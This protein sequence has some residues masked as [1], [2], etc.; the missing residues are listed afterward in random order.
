MIPHPPPLCSAYTALHI[1]SYQHR[2]AGGL[3]YIINLFHQNILHTIT[4]LLQLILYSL[5][6]LYDIHVHHHCVCVCVCV[7]VQL[8]L[9]HGG[10]VSS[11]DASGNTSLHSLCMEDR[12][13]PALPDCISLLVSCTPHTYTI[14]YILYLK[15]V[16]IYVIVHTNTMSRTCMHDCIYQPYTSLSLQ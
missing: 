4:P 1:L 10:S 2:V 3:H 5:C 7:Y 14:T 11:V 12:S 15:S 8:L 16:P 9:E 6:H 13:R